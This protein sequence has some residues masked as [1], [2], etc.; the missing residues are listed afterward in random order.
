MKR[1]SV[2]WRIPLCFCLWA[3][4]AGSAALAGTFGRVVSIGGHASDLALDEARGV[5]YVSNFTANRVEVMS[6]ADGSIQTSM[7]VAAQPSSLSLSP[8]GRFLV[9]G[10]FGNF[11]APNTPANTLTVIDL[12]TR[13]RQTFVLGSPVLGI[14]FAYD[15]LALIVTSTDFQLFDPVSGAT[16]V[17]DTISGLAAKTLPVAPSNFPPNIVAEIQYTDPEYGTD[18][19]RHNDDCNLRNNKRTLSGAEANAQIQRKLR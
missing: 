15:G 7:N 9:V 19:N 10:H 14:A 17:L 1:I 2:N 12:N 13:G 5:L 6:L 11:T 4:L 8:D 16:Q 3:T 18:A